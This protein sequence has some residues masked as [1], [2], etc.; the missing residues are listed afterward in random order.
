MRWR[1]SHPEPVAAPAP[2]PD[3]VPAGRFATALGAYALAAALGPDLEDNVDRLRHP[4]GAPAGLGAQEAAATFAA[5]AGD[6][7]LEWLYAELADDASRELMVRLFAFRLLGA[8]KVRLRDDLEAVTAR[9]AALQVQQDSVDLK[10]LGWHGDRFDLAPLGYRVTLDAHPL[11]VASLVVEQYRSPQHP[12][13]GVHPGDTVI[14]GG[15]CWGDTALYFADQVGAEG[16]VRTF[17][18]EPNNLELLRHNLASNAALAERIDIDERALWDQ[19]GEELT[20]AGNG[21]ATT[22]QIGGDLHVPTATIDA[23]DADRV[24]FIQL[25]IEGAE[26]SALRGAR[27]TLL[28]DRPRLAISLYHR[29][30]DW[31]TIPRF[32]ADLGVGYRF[33]LGHFTV[34]AE[35]TVLF[36]WVDAA[37]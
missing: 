16:R 6:P 21:P 10:F 17:E 29:P 25:D 33:S 5:V 31:T 3:P 2:A 20:L 35:E 9:V 7:G 32:L 13:V 1:R 12:E 15:G 36:A 26:L 34:H 18:F 27:A 11:N 28:R 23:H 22:F 14:D 8:R 19:P 4:D 24:D 37:E 30:D